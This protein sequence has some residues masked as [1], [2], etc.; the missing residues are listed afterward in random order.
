MPRIRRG[1]A[2]KGGYSPHP[3]VVPNFAA[4]GPDAHT[5]PLYMLQRCPPLTCLH[6]QAAL[7]VLPPSRCAQECRR[8]LMRLF[9]SRD[10]VFGS[11]SRLVAGYASGPPFQRTGRRRRAAAAIRGTPYVHATARASCGDGQACGAACQPRRFPPCPRSC[12]SLAGGSTNLTNTHTP[13]KCG[14]HRCMGN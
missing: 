5:P 14:S 6:T 4:T 10:F 7:L 13:L 11:S 8:C 12:R 9:D 2:H 3:A 1:P